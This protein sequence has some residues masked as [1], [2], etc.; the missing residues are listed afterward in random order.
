M[1]TPNYIEKL[2]SQGESQVLDFKFEISNAQKIAK[3]LVAFANTDGG[4]LLIGVK[5]NG[6]I[7]GIRTDEEIFMI[8]SAANIFSRPKINYK[9]KMWNIKGKQ[10]LEIYVPKSP[11]KPFFVKDTDNEWKAYIRVDDNNYLANKIQI[12]VWKEKEK[13]T[14]KIQYTRK[15]EAL[16]SYLQNNK[17]ITFYELMKL[18]DISEKEAENI[19]VDFIILD[20]IEIKFKDKEIFYCYKTPNTSLT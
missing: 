1:K 11:K 10:I 13:R 9:A 17:K 2:I 20:I 7:A 6:A 19:L 3:T 4:R 8:D 12:R 5:D 15:E 14:V 18:A 16:L